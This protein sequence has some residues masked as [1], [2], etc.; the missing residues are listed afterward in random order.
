MKGERKKGK[1]RETS[2][3]QRTEEGQKVYFKLD[4]EGERKANE[5]EMKE[6]WR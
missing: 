4:I 5:E 6:R 3:Q 2:Q 1:K